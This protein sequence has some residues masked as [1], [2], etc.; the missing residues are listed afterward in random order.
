MNR[1]AP[2]PS[3]EDHHDEA[4][5]PVKGRGTRADHRRMA[6]FSRSRRCRGP[7]RERGAILVLTAISM[8]VLL[9]F[10]ALAVDIGQR[11]QKLA[12]AQHSID[13]AVLAAA[14]YLSVHP[15]D[16]AGAMARVKALVQ[17]NLGIPLST[18]VGC[19]DNDHL[20]IVVNGDTNCISFRA[21][22]SVPGQVKN[23][24]RV[25]LP[26]YSMH[27]IF[28]SA[29]GIDTLDLAANAASNGANCV[30]GGAS[31]GPGGSSSVAPTTAAPSTTAAVT[32]TTTLN[33]YCN[34]AWRPP[35]IAFET[36]VY[37]ICK[38]ELPGMD[39]EWWRNYVCNNNDITFTYNGASYTWFYDNAYRYGY[40]W[41]SLCQSYTSAGNRTAWQMRICFDPAQTNYIYSWRD[42][43]NA[44]R[45]V[46]PGM[47]T[48]DAYWAQYNS[49]T[50]TSPPSAT[51]TAEIGRAHV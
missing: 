51:T 22:T 21:N 12:A 36:T 41:T 23:D 43:V 1:S 35:E 45:E 4:I 15:G 32:T 49:T 48:Y 46:N 31:C 25:R 10:T 14:Q 11:N 13:A 37:N 16:Y 26:L 30:G 27:T 5:D 8:I 34:M 50:T 29:L 38:N 18:W 17:E 28:G 47:P 6:E 7:R 44:C 19:N 24:I 39:I 33:Y 20:A 42:V 2:A 3:R 40:Y 9:G